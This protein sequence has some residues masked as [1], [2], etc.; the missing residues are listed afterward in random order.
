MTVL[1]CFVSGRV[2][3]VS[4]R[5]FT[6]QQ[7]RELGLTGWVRNL[8]DG[9]VELMAWGARDRLDLL[10]Q[11]VAQGPRLAKVDT[12]DCLP[13]ADGELEVPTDFSIAR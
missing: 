6:R 4:F 9:R 1:H 2:Q 8:P 10:R 5:A 13:A 7:A 11:S 12:L 3:G